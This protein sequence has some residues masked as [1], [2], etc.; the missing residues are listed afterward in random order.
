MH[1]GYPAGRGRGADRRARRPGG[2][3]AHQFDDVERLCR[4]ARRVRDPDRRR[5]RRAR[6]DLEGPQVG[7]RRGRPDQPRL[8]RAGRRHP[9][10]RAARGAARDRASSPSDSGVRVANVFHAGDGNLHPL[11]LFDDARRGRG[12]A[13]RGGLGR[14]PRPVHRAR[15]LDH[16]RAR[17][18]LGQ[19]EVHAA[20]VHRRRP[21]HDAA[22][23]LRL[24]PRRHLQPRQDLPDAAAV[25]RGAR[26]AHR[27]RTRCVR[28]RPRR[29]RSDAAPAGDRDA[30]AT[31][32]EPAGGHAHDGGDGDAVDGVRP[33]SVAEPARRR[34]GGRG[35]ARCRRGRAGRRGPRRRHQ[36]RPGARRPERPTSSSI[37][38]G[39]DRSLEHAAGDLVVRVQAGARLADVQRALGAAASGS[40]STRRRCRGAARSAGSIATGASGPAAARARRA[41]ATC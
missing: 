14:D 37:S 12:R 24:R 7:V 20:D 6:A 8:H 4:E 34:G 1:C 40:R 39:M 5:R 27:A 11:V 28:G 32:L 13:R 10:H 38:S 29:G 41:C 30:A 17:R 21:R 9:A 25:R 31:S 19:G 23:A 26:P 36:A 15:R 16:R 35:A 2:E 18:G 33:R 3:V 22:G